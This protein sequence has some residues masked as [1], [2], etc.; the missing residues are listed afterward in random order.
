MN[1]ALPQTYPPGTARQGGNDSNADHSSPSLAEN[2]GQ[3]AGFLFNEISIGVL[4]LSAEGVVLECNR[5]AASLLGRSAAE[6][7]GQPLAASIPDIDPLGR[8]KLSGAIARAA[9]ESSRCEVEFLAPGAVHPSVLDFRFRPLAAHG[10]HEPAILAEVCDAA[11]RA[12]ERRRDDERYRLAAIVESSD[13]AIVGKDLKGIVTSWNPAANRLFGYC[14]D[15][16]IGQ[17][18]TKIVPP[19]LAADEARILAALARGERID[20]FE[21]V[22]LRKN[23]ETVDVSLTVS[24][25]HDQAGNIVGAAEIAHD[26]TQQRRAERAL[27]ASERLASVGRLAATVA[28]EI[29]NPLEVIT[30]LVFLARREPSHEQIQKYLSMVEEELE[31]ISHL[32]RQTLSFYRETK[33]MARV[34]L[35]DVVES[36]LTVFAPRMRNKGIEIRSEVDHHLEIFAVPGEIR[37]VVTN[38]LGNSIDALEAGGRI[39]LRVSPAAQRNGGR[40]PGIRLTISDNGP[41]IPAEIRSR[42][43]EPFFTTKK[44]RG[45]GLGLWISK[46]IVESHAGSI[47][48]RSSTTPGKSGTTFSIFLPAAVS[49]AAN[50]L[51]GTASADA[52][53]G[54]A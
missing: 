21:T 7:A 11:A 2:L 24:P 27:R 38:L 35:G 20:H 43:F 10:R 39:C 53:P 30:N 15:E 18:I 37:Q 3:S 9:G 4:L 36:L 23:G 6:L 14:A 52:I 31:R 48:V 5:A 25:V 29:N 46:S 32:T 34:R 28:H 12:C 17:S 19:E 42:L 54:T 13:D 33:G 47:H 51:P 1:S 45:T 16:M 26:I 49:D 41:G 50:D 22:R 40:I 44:D 8:T